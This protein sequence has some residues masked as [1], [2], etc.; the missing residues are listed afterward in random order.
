VLELAFNDACFSIPPHAPHGQIP[1]LGTLHPSKVRIAAT[2]F[3]AASKS[4]HAEKCQKFALT[5]TT[6]TTL[7]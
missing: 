2:A 7:G 1:K 5:Q 3:A 4:A 6:M